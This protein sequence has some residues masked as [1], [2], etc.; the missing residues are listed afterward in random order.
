MNKPRNLLVVTALAATLFLTACGTPS[1]PEPSPDETATTEA[2]PTSSPTP[3]PTPEPI[4]DS[5]PVEGAMGTTETDADGVLR[6]TA[7]EGDVGGIICERFGRAYWQLESG[8]TS[9]GFSC[10]SVIYVGE[11]LTPTNDEKP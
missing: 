8:L 11:V 9:G 2:G 6:Y 1:T 4:V 3:K 7:V 10:N 5:G